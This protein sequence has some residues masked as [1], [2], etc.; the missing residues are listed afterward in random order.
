MNAHTSGALRAAK[1]IMN[2]KHKIRTDYGEKT[3]Y[4]IADLIERETGLPELLEALKMV[5]NIATHPKAKKAE[6]V[7]IAKQARAAIAKAEGR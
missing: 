3:V 7:N 4:G 6:I 5:V 2:D 1:I